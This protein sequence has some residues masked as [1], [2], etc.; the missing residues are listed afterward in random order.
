MLTLVSENLG[1]QKL[2]LGSLFMAGLLIVPQIVVAILAP[3]VGYW[4]ELWGRKPLLLVGFLVETLRALLFALA[5]DPWLLIPIQALDGIT[6][7]IVTVLTILVITDLTTGTGRFN[8]AQGV[9]GAVMAGAAALGTG[10]LGVIVERLGDL[11]G[12]LTMAAV[13][14]AGMALLWIYMPESKPERYVD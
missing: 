11:A 5:G 7:A 1:Q 14:L 2:P 3:W 9:L 10:A 12:F 6:G 8:L 13:V 4:S